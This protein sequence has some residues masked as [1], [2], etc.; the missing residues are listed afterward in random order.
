MHR[1]R[2]YFVELSTDK[3]HIIP[4][5]KWLTFIAIIEIPKNSLLAHVSTHR[6]QLN[7]PS[8][9]DSLGGYPLDDVRKSLRSASYPGFFSCHVHKE[10]RR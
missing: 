4:S 2:K 5:T 10:E 6:K 8:D 7:T 1:N 9:P 3:Y